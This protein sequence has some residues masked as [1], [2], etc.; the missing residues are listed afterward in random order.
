[1]FPPL[2]AGIDGGR[3]RV[4]PAYELSAHGPRSTSSASARE[5][6]RRGG[7][8]APAMKASVAPEEGEVEISFLS[9]LLFSPPLDVVTWER[10]KE[11]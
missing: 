5:K 11:R 6:G 9:S 1:M 4:N 2:S 3:W 7:E 10:A 8:A